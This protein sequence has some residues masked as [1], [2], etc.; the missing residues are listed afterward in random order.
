[1]LC[2]M[3]T[4]CQCLLQA[5]PQIGKERVEALFDRVNDLSLVFLLKS[6]PTSIHVRIFLFL[7]EGVKTKLLQQVRMSACLLKKPF[8]FLRR[9]NAPI[10]LQCTKL[11]CPSG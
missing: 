5:L 6:R 11:L 3:T 8:L 7:K 1:M 10:L 2:F 4:C 9:E